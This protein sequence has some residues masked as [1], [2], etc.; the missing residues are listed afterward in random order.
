MQNPIPEAAKFALIGI[1]FHPQ[2]I[3]MP[4][5]VQD[6]R[7]ALRNEYPCQ[8][9]SDVL[10]KIADILD[11]MR[12]SPSELTGSNDN[13]G[14][15]VAVTLQA[16]LCD[17]T[18]RVNDIDLQAAASEAVENAV[19]YHEQQGFTHALADKVAFGVLEVRTLAIE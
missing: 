7:K 6:N 19:Q 3:S 9:K 13:L 11:D 14:V 2:N 18:D 15:L 1:I 5:L 17:L 12:C 8:T 16:G 10:A 4:W